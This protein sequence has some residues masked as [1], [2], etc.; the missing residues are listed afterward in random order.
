VPGTADSVA[1]ANAATDSAPATGTDTTTPVTT[2]QAN[3]I[4][5]GADRPGATQALSDPKTIAEVDTLIVAAA[6]GITQIPTAIALPMIRRLEEHLDATNVEPL[7]QIAS[8][9]EELR[10]ELGKQQ[11]D[12]NRVGRILIDL[13]NRTN[14][15]GGNAQI[16]GSAAPRLTRLG[17]L[18]TQGGQQLTR[19][20]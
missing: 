3:P 4:V 8:G 9:L 20:R 15:V 1:A 5:P 17:E 7:D 11:I 12:G 2:P 14:A 6:R 18:L 19:G 10:E 13:G 16:A